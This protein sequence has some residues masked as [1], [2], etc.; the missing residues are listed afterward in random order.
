MTAVPNRISTQSI[1]PTVGRRP[2][3]RAH[4][5]AVPARQQPF[6][7]A[8]PGWLRLLLVAQRGSS[9][10]TFVLVAVTI[11]IYGWTVCSQQL[12]SR[13]YQRL[14]N[15]QRQERQTTAANEVLKNQMAREAA[16]PN[17]GLVLP[18]PSNT[19]FLQSA[20]QRPPVAA[21]APQ[22]APLN[23]QKPLAY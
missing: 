15:L 12:W 19:I 13:E 20:P 9:V 18:N 3:S 14:E 17:S 22:F 16:A 2:R 6:T 1:A 5:T 8:I 11:V 21:P 10:L 4:L 7:R 23:P